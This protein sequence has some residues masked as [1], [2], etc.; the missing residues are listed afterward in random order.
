[1]VPILP[2]SWGDCIGSFCTVDADCFSLLCTILGPSWKP[3][4]SQLIPTQFSLIITAKW[5]TKAAYNTA[6]TQIIKLPAC[7]TASRTAVATI[8]T[9]SSPNLKFVWLNPSWCWWVLTMLQN[10]D[11]Q[12]PNIKSHLLRFVLWKTVSV[13]WK[14][15]QRMYTGN[16]WALCLGFSSHRKWVDN[17]SSNNKELVQIWMRVSHVEA[18]STRVE[19][20]R[21]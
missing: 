6:M 20:D 19:F 1:M 21:S 10:Q 12:N 8:T 11:Y 3:D 4:V 5:N 13:S 17:S 16:T 9:N 15:V 18:V 7:T 14:V 2:F